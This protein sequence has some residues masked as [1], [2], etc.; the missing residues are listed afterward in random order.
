VHVIV[1]WIAGGVP[2]SAE[3]AA[4]DAGGAVSDE[5]DEH[6]VIASARESSRDPLSI[7]PLQLAQ[8][9]KKECR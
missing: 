2:G 4:P 6:A 9:D 8:D 5:E 3:D 7:E 1:C